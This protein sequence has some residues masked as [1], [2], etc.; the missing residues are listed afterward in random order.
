MDMTEIKQA[1][2]DAFRPIK[3]RVQKL[4]TNVIDLGQQ[5]SG[6]SEWRGTSSTSGDSLG[7]LAVKSDMLTR[8]KSGDSRVVRAELPFDV[9]AAILSNVGNPATGFPVPP[10]MQIAPSLKV[11]RFWSSLYSRPTTSNAIET[12]TSNPDGASGADAV[13]EGALKPEATLTYAPATVPVATIAFWALAS[14]QLTED[15]GGFQLFLNGEMS[16]GLNAKIDD[17]VINGS[18]IAPHMNGLVNSA[19]A[20]VPSA[21]GIGFDALVGAVVSLRAQGGSKVVIGIGV[22]DYL[23]TMLIKTSDGSYVLSP[24]ANL[25]ESIGATIVPCSAVPAGNFVAAATP[26]GCY[27]AIRQNVTVEIS[28]EDAD[29]FRKNL[30][31]TLVEA[32]MALVVQRASLCLYGPL[33]PAAAPG[34]IPK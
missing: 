12:V 13:A 5:V 21:G 20:F 22:A 27:L 6:K 30:V 2:D 16:N 34:K 1:L 19:T 9:K 26:E 15:A 18:G 31:T 32:R 4:E 8:W 10:D 24:G 28:R 17:E 25:L 14:R 23:S 29:N 7:A 3:E 33:I 11:P